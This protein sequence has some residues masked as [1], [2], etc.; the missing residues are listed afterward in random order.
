MEKSCRED[1]GGQGR[2]RAGLVPEAEKI[3]RLGPTDRLLRPSRQNQNEEN[4]CLSKKKNC[5]EAKIL[6]DFDWIVIWQ[7]GCGRQDMA[8]G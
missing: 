7:C 6:L 5:S 3:M 1:T 4:T 2:F 8:A